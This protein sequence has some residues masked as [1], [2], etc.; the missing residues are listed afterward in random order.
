MGSF[1]VPANT[2]RT[3][4]RSPLLGALKNEN[5]FN[6]PPPPGALTPRNVQIAEVKLLSEPRIHPVS[7]N[8]SL[9]LKAAREVS[10]VVARVGFLPM[11]LVSH[12]PLGSMRA[13]PENIPLNSHPLLNNLVGRRLYS[14]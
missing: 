3:G 2:P 1:D 8:T 7:Q 4:K 14:K 13:N 10:V 5:T 6:V 12:T 11:I 9:V